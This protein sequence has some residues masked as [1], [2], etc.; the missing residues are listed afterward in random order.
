MMVGSVGPPFLLLWEREKD[1]R[2]YPL[3]FL[4]A[5]LSSFIV[6]LSPDCVVVVIVRLGACFRLPAN[7]YP[8]NSQSPW[9]KSR[10][11]KHPPGF[12]S[13][14]YHYVRIISSAHRHWSAAPHRIIIGPRKTCPFSG[15]GHSTTSTLLFRSNYRL[16]S[17]RRGVSTNEFNPREWRCEGDVIYGLFTHVAQP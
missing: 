10:Q 17:V 1:L 14:H 12:E 13:P 9:P 6:I 16:I 11:A 7:K 5:R 2:S 8:P 4:A 15:G 3:P